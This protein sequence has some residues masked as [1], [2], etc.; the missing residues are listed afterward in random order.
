MLEK[1]HTKQ[2]P[3]LIFTIRI[4]D[5]HADNADFSYVS[6]AMDSS[7]AYYGNK[8]FNYDVDEL[9]DEEISLNNSTIGSKAIRLVIPYTPDKQ[10]EILTIYRPRFR[11]SRPDIARWQKM[12]EENIWHFIDEVDKSLQCE[13]EKN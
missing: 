3:K 2:R 9:Y 13:R 10:Y 11:F 8:D 4:N 12:E 5:Y 6:S 7:I 1:Q